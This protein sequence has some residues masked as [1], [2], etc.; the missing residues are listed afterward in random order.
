MFSLSAA[1]NSV[2]SD[3]PCWYPPATDLDPANP[4]AGPPYQSA[5]AGVN[6]HAHKR[7]PSHYPNDHKRHSRRARVFTTQ[8]SQVK[9]RK[10]IMLLHSVVAFL[11]EGN[12]VSSTLGPIVRPVVASGYHRRGKEGRS[13][14]RLPPLPE[15]LYDKEPPQLSYSLSHGCAAVRLLCLWERKETSAVIKSQKSIVMPCKFNQNE[16]DSLEAVTVTIVYA[17]IDYSMEAVIMSSG[18]YNLL[19][20]VFPRLQPSK[21][22]FFVSIP[23]VSTFRGRCPMQIKRIVYKFA[24]VTTLGYELHAR[25][26]DVLP[27]S[28]FWPIGSILVLVP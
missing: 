1:D 3:W 25:A 9:L 18:G 20:K 15:Q 4:G 28:I 26:S 6:G 24:F 5:T 8:A 11:I 23:K 7:L 14:V 16:P 21:L 13:S 19:G 22:P 27:K 2:Q 17:P 12:E 10:R